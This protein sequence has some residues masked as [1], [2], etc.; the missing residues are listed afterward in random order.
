MCNKGL[1]YVED[2]EA[3]S[4]VR[5][6]TFVMLQP[7]EDTKSFLCAAGSAYVWLVT[8]E[9]RDSPAAVKLQD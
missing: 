4:K 7:W 1:F 8:Y 9:T 2:A 5:H 3:L 6:E